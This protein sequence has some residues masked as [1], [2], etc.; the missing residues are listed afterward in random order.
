MH[1]GYLELDYLETMAK[2]MPGDWSRAQIDELVGGLTTA[3]LVRDMG[4]AIY[5]LQPALTGYLRSRSGCLTSGSS[6][7]DDWKRAF[8]H[9]MAV[10]ADSLTPR[11]SH[12]QRGG[13]H[14]HCANFSTALAE[15][16]GLGMEEEEKALTQ[17]LAMWAQNNGNFVEA[18][19]LFQ[20]LAR[21]ED[22][23]AVA[24]HEL[25][26]VALEQRDFCGR[27]AVVSEV[28]RDLGPAGQ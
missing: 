3:G 9:V 25:G 20:K 19:R 15:S 12:E 10:F 21:H 16:E 27:P 26:M 23:A 17:S 11:P 7:A 13:F 4:L 1:E 28:A 6:G 24:Y 18:E 14:L 22:M 5:E 8:V 2:L